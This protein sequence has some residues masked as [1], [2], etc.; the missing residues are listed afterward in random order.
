MAKKRRKR[1]NKG[2]FLKTRKRIRLVSDGSKVLNFAKGTLIPIALV[3][4]AAA[5]Y[6]LYDV[7]VPESRKKKASKAL[8]QAMKDPE[9]QKV[10]L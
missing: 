2:P 9:S 8:R 5:A 7:P 4:F 10:Y 6:W 1:P 3:V